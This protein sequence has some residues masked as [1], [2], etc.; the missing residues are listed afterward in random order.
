MGVDPILC[1]CVGSRSYDFDQQKS[2][3]MGEW[4]GAWA[5]SLLALYKEL[6]V[7]HTTRELRSGSISSCVW[8]PNICTGPASSGRV[9]WALVF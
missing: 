5:F 8:R 6:D 4:V 9:V 7:P 2:G 3:A 1:N